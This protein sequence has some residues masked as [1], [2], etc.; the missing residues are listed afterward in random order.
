M[1]DVQSA[2]YNREN[3][4]L[5][6]TVDTSKTTTKR[7]EIIVNNSETFG[8]V[9]D[10]INEEYTFYLTP[11]LKK[12]ISISSLKIKAVGDG[13]YITDSDYIDVTIQ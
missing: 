5:R 4:M 11:Y 13:D 3:D 10:F 2:T 9:A 7:F 1:A 6:F 12:G 8:F